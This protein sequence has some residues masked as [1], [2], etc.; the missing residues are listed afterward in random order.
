M[1]G[2]MNVKLTV[3]TDIKAADTP[4]A[5]YAWFEHVCSLRSKIVT[6]HVQFNLDGGFIAGQPKQQVPEH[7]TMSTLY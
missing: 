1:H 2:P 6:A 4:N 7:N 5:M 3:L